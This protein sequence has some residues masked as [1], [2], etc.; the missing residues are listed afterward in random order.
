[1]TQAST[2][3]ADEEVLGRAY[4]ARLMRRIWTYTR[5]YRGLLVLAGVVFP[6]LALVEL[7]QPY[8]VKVAIDAHILRGDWAGLARVSGLFLVALGVQCALRYVQA[9]LLGTLGHRV[10]HDLRADLFAHVQRQPAAF[11]DRNPVGRLMTRI[12][13]DVEAVGEL[14]ASGLVAI[15]GDLV[16]L[17][18]VIVVMLWLDWRLALVTLAAVPVL[19]GVGAFFRTRARSAYREVRNRIARVNVHLQ[20]ALSG[21][22]VVQVFNQE[23]VHARAFAALNE[24]HRRAVFHRMRY[25]ALLYA[26]V[27]LVGSVAIAALLW[28]GGAQI[29]DGTLTFG[30]LVAFMEYVNRFFLP[31]RDLS[32]KYTVMQAAMVGAE[33][34]FGLLDTAPAIVSPAGGHRPDLRRPAGAA[35]PA[36]ELRDVWLAYGDGVAGTNGGPAGASWAL[37]G[38]S[39]AIRPGERV[40]VVGATGSGKTSLARLL[41]RTYEATRGAVLV[42]GVDVR[43]WDLQAL[44]RHV[45]LV[46]QDVVIFSGTV[47]ENLTLGRPGATPAV[48]EDAARRAHAH[49]FI[50]ALP[51]GYDAVLQERGGNLS[52]GQ[53]QL[54]SVARALVYNPP[55]LVLD[56]ATSS[57]DPETERWLQDA[58]DQLLA[59]RTSVVIA[60]RFSTI[61]RADRI[62]VFQHGELR[63]E[64][65]H[66]AL[67]QR[68]GLYATLHELQFGRPDPGQRVAIAPG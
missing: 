17:T 37:R 3:P 61:Q 42:D 7:A 47:E 62:L 24:G 23:A 50:S 67:L 8:L 1:V 16:T 33:R 34:I 13:G 56:E 15:I 66:A 35:T 32:A 60:H 12:L 65:S 25:D 36:L 45:G 14:F 63:E 55:V 6:L 2:P 53:R 48:L 27:E 29:L 68:G 30:V 21:M 44:R 11:F 49:G 18:G 38:V 20:E 19:F 9:S 28:Q 59:G 22:T 10:V 31:I 43:D 52:H 46:L 5:P 64:G 58:V 4:D 51:S 54:L 40:A 41:T 57:V 39:L 26:G